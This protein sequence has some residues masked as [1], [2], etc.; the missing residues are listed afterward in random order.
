MLNDRKLKNTK[1]KDKVYE[2]QDAEGLN[3]R[4]NTS[5]KLTFVH[6]YRFEGKQ[7]RN[8]L[9]HYPALSLADARKKLFEE[10]QLL[11]DGINPIEHNK[12]LRQKRIKEPTVSELIDEFDKRYLQKELKRP[13]APMYLLKKDVIPSIGERKVTDVSRRELVYILDKIVD[14]GSPVNAN[15]TLSAIKKLFSY[16]VERG[17]LEDNITL[18][19][20]KKSIGGSEKP[21]ERFLDLKEIKVFWEK[22]DNAPFSRQVQLVLK[23]IL[24]SGLRVDEVTGAEKKEINFQRRLWF[25]PKER[26]KNKLPHKVILTDLIEHI[27]RELMFI[28]G[29]S[30]YL[31]QSPK[32]TEHKP[33]VYTAISRA[34]KRH[35]DHFGLEPW[36][37]LDLRRTVSTQLSN[38]GIAPHIVEKTLNHKMQGV[39][40][41]YNKSDYLDERR[42]AMIKW[43]RKLEKIT[44]GE[45][46]IIE[47]KAK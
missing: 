47:L 2:I 10:K 22:I 8:N 6:R 19:I 9:G 29:D 17:I 5:G 40:A 42:K 3:V 4:V 39:M 34:V 13:K 26:S 21:R 28:S 41:V 30:P 46:N 27:L 37:P 15:R 1:P 31:V 32:I 25:I 18:A 45:T 44:A 33:I 14:R 36:V 16:A 35:Q 38:L 20:S 11:E 12:E 43:M 24:A 23:L 7:Y